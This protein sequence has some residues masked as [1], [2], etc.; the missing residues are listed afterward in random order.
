MSALNAPPLPRPFQ[1][2]PCP[3][4][5]TMTRSPFLP[6]RRGPIAALRALLERAF[7][8]T[9]RPPRQSEIESALLR[10]MGSL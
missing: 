7:P 2:G 8:R 10:A 5:H 4:G 1:A 9:P 3:N 6:A